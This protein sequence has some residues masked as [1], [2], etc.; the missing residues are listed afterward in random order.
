MSNP[1]IEYMVFWT[2]ESNRMTLKLDTMSDHV[3]A[4][5]LGSLGMYL[6]LFLGEM[7]SNKRRYIVVFDV[8]LESYVLEL[9]PLKGLMS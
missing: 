4:L 8:S 3:R 7:R 6:G 1:N 2:R 5:P 9:M